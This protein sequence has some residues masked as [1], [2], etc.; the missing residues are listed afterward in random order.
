MGDNIWR[1]GPED[2]SLL[3]HLPLHMHPSSLLLAHWLP[4]SIAVCLI[5]IAGTGTAAAVAAVAAMPMPALPLAS[6]LVHV[7]PSSMV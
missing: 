5:A 7:R 1:G 4:R 3:L 6:P 2:D